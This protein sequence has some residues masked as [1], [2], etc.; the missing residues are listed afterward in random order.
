MKPMKNNFLSLI[1]QNFIP[2]RFIHY[3]YIFNQVKIIN[4]MAEKL[5]ILV[6]TKLRVE[7]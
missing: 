6:Y 1:I 5:N 7:E 4:I 3:F 2:N